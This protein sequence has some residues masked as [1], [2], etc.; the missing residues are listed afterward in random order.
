MSP[1][2]NLKNIL[3]YFSK[4]NTIIT[5]LSIFSMF[6]QFAYTYVLRRID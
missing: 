1:L 3:N 5:T 4:E 6:K 2:I